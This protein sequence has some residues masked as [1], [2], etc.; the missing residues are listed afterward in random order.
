MYTND[1]YGLENDLLPP[2]VVRAVLGEPYR[3]K[4]GMPTAQR[5]PD[6]ADSRGSLNSVVA[7]TQPN[8]GCVEYP[9][10]I[11]YKEAQALPQF[12]IWYKHTQACGCT[13]CCG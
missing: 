7:I 3:T 1:L 2:Q 8:G 10:Y 9:E 5:P 11:V 6:R 4:V 13:H 12:A